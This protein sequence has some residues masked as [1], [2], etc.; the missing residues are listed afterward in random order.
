MA[1]D[2]TPN[3]PYSPI[4]LSNLIVTVAN[5]PKNISST[6]NPCV[7]AKAAVDTVTELQNGDLHTYTSWFDLKFF[8][9]HAER[10]SEL[11]VT[12]GTRISVN[13]SVKFFPYERK[14]GETG[15]NQVIEVSSFSVYA[16]K[17]NNSASSEDVDDSY[18]DSDDNDAPS[19]GRSRSGG[20]SSGRSGGR[21]RSAGRS[22]SG[23]ASGRSRSADVDEDVDDLIEDVDL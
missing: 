23:R 6:G 4:Y 16:Y 10:L 13:G 19:R 3:R 7:V 22:G 5:D 2:Y 9:Y 18:D 21:G 14:D 15:Y 11:N 17:K 12:K 20:R 8:G 1:K